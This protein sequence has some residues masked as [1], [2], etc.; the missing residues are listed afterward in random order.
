MQMWETIV[1][2][3]GGM[4][5]AAFMHLARR[6]VRTLGIERFDVA[7]DRGSSHGDTRIIRKAYFEHP[8][9]VPLAKQA[10]DGWHEIEEASGQRLL[11]RCGLLLAGPTEGDVIAGTRAAARQHELTLE[12]IEPSD[13][14][15]HYPALRPT[16]D[17]E[18]LLER[19]AGFLRVEDCV[20]TQIEL[21]QRAG[22]T[23]ALNQRVRKWHCAD[24]VVEVQTD[25]ERYRARSAII[26]TGPWAQE[27]LKDLGL[28][29]AVQ[30]K[31]QLWFPT[32]GKEFRLEAPCPVFGFQIADAFYYGFPE[33]RAGMVKLAEHTGASP[34]GSA[35]ALDRALRE[36]DVERVRGFARTC[37]APLGKTPTR[38]AA[39]LYT[40]TRDG[41]FIVDRHP[42]SPNVALAVGFSGHGFKFAPLIGEILVDLI[43]TGQTTAPVGFLGLGRFGAGESSAGG[44]R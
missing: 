41:H 2:G 43:M 17:M 30:R 3:L 11:E 36:S 31:M 12:T 37:L 16:D 25:S 44:L 8:D 29:L 19:D 32:I 6:G 9:Y 7:H 20:R 39:C 27:L 22:G 42:Q 24:G 10:Y 23:L 34:V 5:S 14:R 4:G 15:A 13:V 38:H 18:V 35:D 26:T 40:M 1:I 33:V 21:G 28:P